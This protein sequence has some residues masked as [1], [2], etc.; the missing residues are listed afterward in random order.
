MNIYFIKFF[1]MFFVSDDIFSIQQITM[2]ISK[3][4]IC[5]Q[6]KQFPFLL[7]HTQ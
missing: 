1:F 4:H 2:A 6:S 5:V 7:T 3:A